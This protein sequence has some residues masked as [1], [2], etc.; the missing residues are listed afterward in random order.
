[1]AANANLSNSWMPLTGTGTS[2]VYPG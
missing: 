2:V 1:M